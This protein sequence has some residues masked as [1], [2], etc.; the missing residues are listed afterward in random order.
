MAD[1]ARALWWT[2]PL[3]SAWR[4][5][6][7]REPGADEVLVET[8]VT[9]ISRGTERLV[10]TGRVPQSQW[11]TM[12]CPHQAGDFPFPVKYGYAAVGLVRAGPA[13]LVGHRV[14]CLHPHQNA[15]V[16]PAADCA[17]L[18]DEVDSERAVLAAN[19]ETA[20]NA[21][22]DS[23][24][25]VGDRITV[26]GA[27]VVGGL[28][29]WLLAHLPGT[30]VTLVDR[31]PARA[32]LAAAIGVGFELPAQA[33]RA[34]DLVIEA[35]GAAQA[36]EL[37]LELAGFEATILAVGWYGDETVGLRLGGAFHSRRLRLVSSQVGSV[38]D[39]QRAR[40]SHARRIAKA[41]ELLRD[42]ALD[43]FLTGETRW[44]DLP[45]AMPRILTGTDAGLCHRVRFR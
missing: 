38:A 15:F 42:P 41:V 40:W 27:G 25:T 7:L 28:I 37:A 18:P 17:A 26:I 34:A 33:P 1:H 19:L 14:F 9:G 12:R 24:A 10:A 11:Q 8:I 36:L 6:D 23:G 45:S 39:R 30:E 22:W 43:I 29:A 4:E 20:L 44:S 16:V 3:V 32:A 2:A 13:E 31:E 21:V 5:E 35:S